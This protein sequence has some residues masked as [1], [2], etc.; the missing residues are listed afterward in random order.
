MNIKGDRALF[1]ACL[2]L[3]SSTNILSAQAPA[4]K[5]APKAAP[6]KS[7]PD[8]EQPKFKA[9]W[10]PVN[11]PYDLELRSVH[12]TSAEEGWVAGG[13]RALNGGVILHTS[14]GGAN[15]EIQIGDTE[16]SDRS[17][18]DLRFLSPTL[19]WAA[20]STSGGDHR[21][22]RTTDGKIWAPAGTV[23]QNRTDY[24]FVSRDVGF[25]TSGDAIL[26]TA[27]GGRKW[28]PVYRCKVRTEIQGLTR[29]VACDFSQMH[30]VNPN[31]GFTISQELG[32]DGGIVFAKTEDGGTTW[33]TSVVLP[34]QNAK[35]GAIH[36]FD[37]N[38]G[39]IRMIDGKLFH[40]ADGGK[41]W[42]E[43]SGVAGG[44][45]DIEFADPQVGWMIRYRTMTYTTNG[46]QS[47]VSREIQFPASVEAFSLVQR[48]RG[49]AVGDHG[50]VYRYRVVPIEYTSKGML[51]APAM[52]GR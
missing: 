22:L 2:L 36:F 8:K 32:R 30:F 35:E 18:G 10:E 51:G 50:M 7:A 9:I 37:A 33:T 52:P 11:V 41:T 40:T 16:S 28:D 29:E 19:G 27:D 39:V 3:I 42:N 47:W 1:A 12:F 6:A 49:Y 34:G 31:L 38:T 21:L 24:E 15:W 48:D 26:R 45:P 5:A 46:G 14:D 20:Q 44:K 13:K 4:K 23:A 43:A 25:V 17:Y